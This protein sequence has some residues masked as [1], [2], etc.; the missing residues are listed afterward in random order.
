MNLKRNQVRA[1]QKTKGV[2]QYSSE[3]SSA[4][5]DEINNN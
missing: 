5:F 4:K 2:V 3:H 1:L